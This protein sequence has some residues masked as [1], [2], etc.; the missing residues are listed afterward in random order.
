MERKHRHLLNVARAVRFE[1]H[2]PIEFWGECAL[3]AAYLINRTPS[4]VLH[5]KTPYEVLYG[6][7][8]S[9]DHLRVMGC[10]CY[11]HNQEHKGDKFASRSGK[12]VFVGYPYGKKGWRVFDLEKGTFT[13]SRDV[14]FREDTFHYLSPQTALAEDPIMEKEQV[15]SNVVITTETESTV[16]E[17]KDASPSSLSAP[18]LIKN[19]VTPVVHTP[20][21]ILLDNE[22]SEDVTVETAGNTETEHVV[23]QVRVGER[24]RR[25]PGYLKDYDTS[26]VCANSTSLYPIADVVTCDRFSAKHR[27]FLAAITNAHEPKIFLQAM[28]DERWKNAVGSE[29]GS[30]ELN[31]TWTL[32]DL[33]KEKRQLVANGYSKSSIV[34]TDQSKGIKQDW[35]SWEIVK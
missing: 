20:D 10:V 18:V 16:Q 14:I 12:C 4:L 7:Q 9:Y 22:E 32:E 1:G 21:P 27:V 34:L 11:I 5:G 2:L 8:P 6:K 17:N 25:A 24:E 29:I 28:K 15:I 19:E 23:A 13:V 3:T 33:P 26:F 31:K 35:L 30:L